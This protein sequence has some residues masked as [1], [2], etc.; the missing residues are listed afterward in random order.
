MSDGFTIGAAMHAPT[1]FECPHCKETIDSTAD[2][3]RFCG[4][5]VDHEAAQQAG[6][7]MARINQA[8]SDASYMKSTAVSIPVFFVLRFIPFASMLGGVGFIG[9]SFVV[10]IW[11]VRWWLK[12]GSIVSDD[13]DFR[14]ARS[15]VKIAGILVSVVLVLLVILP[16]LFAFS[17]GLNR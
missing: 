12:F 6:V 1:I 13:A 3:C 9:L 7:L 5:K 11:A 2:S 15:T 14:K 8:C 16:F 4:A 10:P 17:R